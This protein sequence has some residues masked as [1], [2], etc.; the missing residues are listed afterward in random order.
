VAVTGRTGDA[1]DVVI[2]AADR[3]RYAAKEGGRN[4]VQFADRSA[5]AKGRPKA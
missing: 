3:A 2:A 1:A 4:R 5:P